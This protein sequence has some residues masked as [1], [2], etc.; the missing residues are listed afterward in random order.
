MV[1]AG[2]LPAWV[3]L[4][5]YWVCGRNQYLKS[6]VVL[7]TLGPCVFSELGLPLPLAQSGKLGCRV[8]SKVATGIGLKAVCGILVAMLG[9]GNP[10]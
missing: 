9:K 4:G 1:S 6:L 3:T 10:H 8:R 5:E 7:G 2:N